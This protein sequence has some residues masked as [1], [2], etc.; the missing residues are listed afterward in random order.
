MREGGSQGKWGRVCGGR[1]CGGSGR[2]GGLVG[3]VRREGKWSR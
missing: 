1:V 2:E 3:V